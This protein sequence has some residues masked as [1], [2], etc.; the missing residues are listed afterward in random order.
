MGSAGRVVLTEGKPENVD[1]ARGYFDRAGLL[2][3][4]VFE[5]GNGLE[6]IERYPGPFD[7]VFLDLDKHDYP[8]ALARALP[9]LR[10][11]G[12]LIADNTLWSG[13]AARPAEDDAT[14]GIQEFNR[15]VMASPDLV[16]TI[17]PLRDGVLVA[18]R[19]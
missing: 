17:L 10:K 18:V 2:D 3:R 1:A 15:R 14:R 8:A 7:I 19:L 11:G 12:L 9:R 4:A 6:A 16:A 13:K 5:T